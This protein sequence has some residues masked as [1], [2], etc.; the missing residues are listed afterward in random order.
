M[1]GKKKVAV[2]TEYRRWTHADTNVGNI[3]VGYNHDGKAGPDC[4]KVE[5]CADKCYNKMMRFPPGR[6]GRAEALTRNRSLV[7][8]R[9][10]SDL[11]G[12]DS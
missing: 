9:Q 2:V 4:N 1:G 11:A 5:C 12:R 7:R 8:H 6:A 10:P 3:V